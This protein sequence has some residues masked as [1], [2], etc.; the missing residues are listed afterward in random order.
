M[1]AAIPPVNRQPGFSGAS[2]TGQPAGTLMSHPADSDL[3]F[4][5]DTQL[6]VRVQQPVTA[7]RWK[8]APMDLL[9]Q[10][11]A[12]LRALD[13]PVAFLRRAGV[14]GAAHQD[15][16]L[17]GEASYAET[18]SAGTV[19]LAQIQLGTTI[20]GR[21]VIYATDARGID[22]LIRV[23]CLAKDGL[24]ATSA[25]SRT[26]A[27]CVAEPEQP[28]PEPDTVPA[29]VGH[30]RELLDRAAMIL[31][32]A[33]EPGF[34]RFNDAAYGLSQSADLY[35][36]VRSGSVRPSIVFPDLTDDGHEFALERL[37][38]DI[39]DYEATLARVVDRYCGEEGTAQLAGESGAEQ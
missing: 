3:P 34:S 18:A 38:E 17:A 9:R 35:E 28:S 33:Y 21:P 22:A 30:A 8:P 10:V 13:G 27:G 6:P 23:A 1:I 31:L 12:G 39:T 19:Q 24:A 2:L 4:I 11:H 37:A 20:T 32:P 5:V 25:A 14:A 16:V 29:V 15:A 26:E 36:A 7:S